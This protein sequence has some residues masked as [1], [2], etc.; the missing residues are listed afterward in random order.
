[1]KKTDL[2]TI[3]E[4]RAMFWRDN[5]EF[6]YG[7]GRRLRGRRLDAFHAAWKAVIDKAVSDG[8]ISEETAATAPLNP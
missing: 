8:W 7:R 4:L 2:V 3:K 1:M 6:V 5:P